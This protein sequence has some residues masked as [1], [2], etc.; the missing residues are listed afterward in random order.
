MS[1]TADVKKELTM[2][3]P[4]KKCC[5]LAEIAMYL[6]LSGT[7]TLRGGVGIR[8]ATDNPAVARFYATQIK[9]YFGIKT[10]LAVTEGNTL[11]KSRRYELYIGPEMNSD[12]VLRECGILSVREG[13]NIFT[14]SIDPDITRKKCCKRSA[15]KGAFLASGSV[16][17]PSAKGYHL[18]ITCSN[19]T[20]AEEVKKL[21]SSFGL[22]GR[23][24]HRKEKAV[25]YLKA[26]EQIID[27]LS[28]VGANGSMFKFRD[29]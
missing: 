5:Q 12:G 16:N 10:S 29:T 23:I 14:D 28:L 13:N 2:L 1:F 22:E 27:F 20:M 9:D 18:E 4:S 7:I 15:L 17:A 25:V 11:N 24:T 26:G 6:R 8:T 3:E 19:E 21:M